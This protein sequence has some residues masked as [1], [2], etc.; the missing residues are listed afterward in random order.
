[1][2]TSARFQAVLELISTIFGGEV[3]ADNVINE[4]MR[5]RKFIGSKD[6][7][8]I[9]ET[10]WKIIRNR[11]KL[12]FDA[13]SGE[14][15]KLVMTFIKQNCAEN[16]SEIFTG[17]QYAP[18]ALTDDERVWL[19]Q[20]NEEV[21]PDYVEAECPQW[22]YE[23]IN[24]MAL[25]KSLNNPA[26]ADFRINVKSREAVIDG[27][28]KEG[29]TVFPTP[30]SP[31]GLRSEERVSLG[32]CMAY[33]NG[34]IEVQDEASQLAAIL[35]DVKPEHKVIDYCCGAGG[36]S[37]A[38][39][40]LLANKGHILAH[41]IS[42][43]RLVAI[44]PR[45]Q[46]LGIKNIELLDLVATS[47]KDFDR[48]IIDA[49]CSG[50]GTWRRSPDAKFRLTPKTIDKL[51][52]A[53]LEILETAYE[54]VKIGG[55]I[56][57]ITCSTLTDENEAVIHKFMAEKNNLALVSIKEIWQQKIGAPYPC[58]SE[59]FLRLSPLTTGTDGFFMCVIEKTA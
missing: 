44:K 52:K 29:I 56:I 49:P 21:Y 30:Y 57:Y 14:Y 23:K 2:Q 37:L 45:L 59:K 41:D 12:E 19:E 24:D 17:A 53:Q 7:R 6:R 35:C 40:Y 47:D 13:R 38:I 8:F 4:Y 11:M 50:T 32:N 16:V 31:I 55:R 27:L 58:K 34:E 33:Q 42:A 36:K 43:K 20:E 48:F 46:R 25:L 18:A 1:M 39:A 51:N 3:P 28:A 9:T 26:S 22:L 10:V 54:K 15:R 5:A